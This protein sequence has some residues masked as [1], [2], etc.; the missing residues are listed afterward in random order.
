[1]HIPLIYPQHIP[2]ISTSKISTSKYKIY[3]HPQ[4]STHDAAALDARIEAFLETVPETLA[5]LTDEEFNKNRQAL[6]D[7]KL[8]KDKRLREETYR[9]WNEMV[10]KSK[11]SPQLSHFPQPLSP[12]HI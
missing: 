1:M 6:V 2:K 4:S 10:T 11:K 3:L 5:T 9:Y 12:P 7:I 8:E